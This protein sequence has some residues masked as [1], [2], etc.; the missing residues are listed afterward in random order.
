MANVVNK[1]IR[2]VVLT[3]VLFPSNPL[4]WPPPA[5]G[6]GAPDDGKSPVNLSP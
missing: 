5:V 4:L 3:L 1:S 6:G 2:V